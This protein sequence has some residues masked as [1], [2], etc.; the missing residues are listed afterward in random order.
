MLDK[1][2][3]VKIYCNKPADS[4]SIRETKLWLK[5][6]VLP[7]MAEAAQEG[8]TSYDFYINNSEISN[9]EV[10]E[11]LRENGYYVSWWPVAELPGRMSSQ[12][13]FRIYW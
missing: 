8:K 2:T 5:I 3:F 6:N 10:Y 11:I 7:H 12:T 13:G 4:D 1:A 9:K